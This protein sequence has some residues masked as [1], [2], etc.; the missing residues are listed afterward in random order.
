[1]NVPVRMALA[2]SVLTAWSF[3]AAAQ[4]YYPPAPCATCTDGPVYRVVYQTVYEQREVTAYRIEYETVCEERQVTTY[5]PEWHTEIRDTSYDRVRYMQETVE[6]EERYTVCRPVWETQEREERYT[7]RRPIYETAYRTEYHTVMRPVVTLRTEYVDQGCF[8]E[9]MVFKPGFPRTRLRW[10]PGSTAIDPLTG[11]AV[12]QRG[13]LYWVQT[14]RGRYEVQRVWQPNLVAR[15]V[16][17]T[18]YCP[19]VVAR[20]VPVQVCRYQEEQVV[21]KVP[22][23]VCRMVREEHVRKVPYTV[24]RPITERVEQQVEVRV[25][26]MVP[27][28]ETVRVPR[29]VE[30]RIPVTYTY[31]VPRVVCHRVPIDPCTG[32]PIQQVAVPAGTTELGA[33]G[34]Q[35]PTPAGASVQGDAA[36]EEKPR[37]D[38]TDSAPEPLDGSQEPPADTPYNGTADQDSSAT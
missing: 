31:C 17:Q 28:T 24:S 13:G 1:M 27:V 3:P 18:T 37:I 6:R 30:K 32:L 34:G 20:Q 23:R 15:Q 8:A 38:E 19:E 12:L 4:V 11:A 22:Y 35:Q 26:R 21:R 29:V 33:T 16:E 14:P 25:C 2:L 10:V 7:V 36:A 9:Q 5:R